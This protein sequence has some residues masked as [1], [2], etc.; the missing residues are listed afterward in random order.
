[1]TVPAALRRHRAS[2]RGVSTKVVGIAL[3]LCA[4]VVVASAPRAGA[5]PPPPA[6]PGSGAAPSL[7]CGNG[8]L[9]E[10]RW[11]TS[12]WRPYSSTSPFN[13]QI[14][15]GARIAPDSREI[16]ARL[17]SFG[18]ISNLV[19]GEADSPHDFFH[20]VYFSQRRDPVF[21][22]HCYQD[23]W[24]RCP[25][26]GDRIRIPNAARPAGGGD[27]HLT[28]ISRASG[29]EYDFYK[30]RS[31]PR[32]GGTLV[33]RWGGRT[34]IGGDGLGSGATAS[35]FG[36]AAGIIRAAELRAGRIDHALFMVARC[37]AGSWVYPANK[38]GS[39]CADRGIASDGAPP[40]GARL[41]LAMSPAQIAALRV[42]HWKKTILRAMARYGLYLGDTGGGAWGVQL[43]S[44]SSYT[45]FGRAD[46]L[47]A[48][49]RTNDWRRSGSRYIGDLR[50]GVDWRRY[51]RVIDPC[52][53]R[54][55]C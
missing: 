55:S 31:K 11:P 20:P 27:A 3:G 36:G 14:P 4:S 54:R 18:P 6:V 34:L 13:R 44:G 41:Q 33:F 2:L 30:V 17:L 5:V 45:S 49:A 37:D 22:L 10:G 32:G 43:E 26:E 7:S 29:W 9:F 51:L 38:S 16:V 40:M 15:N 21:T 50:A 48:F 39:S 53:T 42:P 12:C 8:R 19:A 28:V 25:I 24:G 46:P 1:V 23:S 35:G 47:V 52:V